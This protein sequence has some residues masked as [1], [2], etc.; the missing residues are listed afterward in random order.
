MKL[1]K[2]I[3]PDSEVSNKMYYGKTK[4]GILI[5]D[6]LVL[7]SIELILSDFT[8]MIVLSTVKLYVT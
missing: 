5:A 8:W 3:F 2:A 7:Y 1:S 6:E 4:G